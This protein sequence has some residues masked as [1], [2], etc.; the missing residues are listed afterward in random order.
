MFFRRRHFETLLLIS[1]LLPQGN[2]LLLTRGGRELSWIIVPGVLLLIIGFRL[3]KENYG[4]RDTPAARRFIL[5]F[6]AAIC[7]LLG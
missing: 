1:G 7:V 5:G 4:R 6:L 3:L 2:C